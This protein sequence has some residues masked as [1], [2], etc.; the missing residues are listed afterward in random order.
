MSLPD[1]ARLVGDDFTLDEFIDRIPMIGATVEK[2]EGDE[3][4][5]EF[6]P[7]RPDLFCV[8][9]VARAYRA[10]TGRGPGDDLMKT[11]KIESD[12]GLE[13][14]VD[15]GMLKVRPV[16]GAAY[17]TGVEID[18]KALISI[19][20]LQEKLHITVG[21]KR[22]KVAIGIHDADPLKGPFRFWPALPEEVE[23]VPLQKEGKWNLK[24]ILEEHEKGRDYAWTVEGLDR[25]PLITDSKDDVLSFPPIIN[26]ELTR[27]SGRTKNIFVDCTGWD[28]N[29]VSLA[30]NIVCSQLISRGGKLHSVK[31]I[32]PEGKGFEELGLRTGTWPLYDWREAVMD[33]DWA[34]NWL[35]KELEPVEI[36]ASLQKMGYEGIKIEGRMITCLVPPWRGDI[37]HQADIAEDLAIGFGFEKFEGTEPREPMVG[38]ERKLTTISRALRSTLV[39]MGFLEVRTISLS[40]EAI[41]FGLMGREESEHVKITN[42]ITTEHTMMRMSAIPSLLSLLRSNKHRDL[43]QRIFEVSDVMVGNRNRVLLTGLS[44]DNK[45]SFTEIKGIIQRLLSDLGIEFELSPAPPGCYIRGRGA[46]VRIRGSG[47][48]IC[49]FPELSREGMISVGHFGEIHPRMISEMELSTP[50]SGFEMDLQAVIENIE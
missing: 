36:S 27:V 6:F 41:Q 34:G 14:E 30:V 24:R 33:L 40:N 5:V 35:G 21:R 10:F 29:A 43:P 48:E 16:M 28:L 45:A 11:M 1:L 26:G 44:E 31:V 39:G 13:L 37:L 7:D 46:A 18:E 38:S 47:G 32:Y 3:I 23:F 17:I 12:S 4:T 42:P 50:I 22:K 9:G 19:M 8:E 2:V 49:P 15:P 20:N 25:Y